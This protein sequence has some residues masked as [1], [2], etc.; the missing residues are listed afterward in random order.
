MGAVSGAAMKVHPSWVGVQ[1]NGATLGGGV[2]GHPRGAYRGLLV[3]LSMFSGPYKM[4]ACWVDLC[5][6]QG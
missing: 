1:G 5:M 2:Q 4:L 3:P 6:I